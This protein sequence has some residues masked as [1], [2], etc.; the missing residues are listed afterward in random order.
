MTHCS[1]APRALL[2]KRWSGNSERASGLRMEPLAISCLVES[3]NVN[4][5]VHL[6]SQSSL[7]KN[8]SEVVYNI[9]NVQEPHL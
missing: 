8:V 1:W 4:L 9:K 3:Q 5:G 2:N 6:F 7:I